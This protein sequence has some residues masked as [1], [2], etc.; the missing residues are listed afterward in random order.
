MVHT[1][2]FILEHILDIVDMVVSHNM[3]DME[4]INQA[5]EVLY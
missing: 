4:D 2:E 5:L 3:A 1:L